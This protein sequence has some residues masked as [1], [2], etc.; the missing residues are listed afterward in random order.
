MSLKIITEL[1]NFIKIKLDVDYENIIIK[2]IKI[3]KDSLYT[4]ELTIQN[5]LYSIIHFEPLNPIQGVNYGMGHW[6]DVYLFN[7]ENNYYE[8]IKL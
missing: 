3:E 4:I 8:E 2:S 7:K 6:H 1:I 5:V